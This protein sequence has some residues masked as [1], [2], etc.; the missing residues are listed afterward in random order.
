M[1]RRFLVPLAGAL[2]LVFA[3]G[4][5]AGDV[6]ANIAAG[7]ANPARPEAQR[8]RDANRKPAEILAFAGVKPGDRVGDVMMGG[9]YFTRIFSGAVGPEGK[10]YAFQ[11]TEFI[12]FSA[13]YAKG[14]DETA[15]FAPNIVP[16]RAS[17]GAMAFPEPLD[18]IFTAQNYHDLHLGSATPEQIAGINKLM[19]AALKPGGVLVL[20]DHAAADGSGDRDSNKLHR[21]DI[22]LVK[23]ELAA[24]GFVLEAE[25]DVLR[26]PA[27]ARTISVF[28]PAINGKTDQFV[29][30]FRKPK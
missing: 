8:A 12:A 1:A 22:A 29:L 20:I 5:F 2:S 15:K 25:S 17:L 27:D 3:A 14:Q 21:I 26:N 7:V 28:D 9:G 23:A 10:V 4:A 16:V 19:F 24:A 11:S 18:V 13:D 6:P 30:K